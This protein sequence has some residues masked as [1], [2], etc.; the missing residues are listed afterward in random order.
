MVRALAISLPL[1][2]PE[3]RAANCCWAPRHRHHIV[4]DR[5]AGQA[6]AGSREWTFTGARLSGHCAV[7][8][9][10]GP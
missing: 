8:V 3:Q 5:R 7:S 4:L 6:A 1:S 9:R 2:G 10:I